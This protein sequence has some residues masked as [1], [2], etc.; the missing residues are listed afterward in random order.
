MLFDSKAD[1]CPEFCKNIRQY[2][3]AHAFTS[4]GAKIDVNILQ[5]H[6]SYSFGIHRE[7]RHLL[8][9]LLPNADQEATYAQLYIYDPDAHKILLQ[10]HEDGTDEDVAIYLHHKNMTDKHHYNLPMINK[11]MCDIII[12]LCKDLLER[13]HERHPA[14]LPLHYVLLF[15]H[16][17][18]GWHKGLCH[19]LTDT[20]EQQ[21]D[22][23]NK[24]SRL[25]QMNFYSFHI[26]PRK[27]EFST[28][29]QGEKL[30]HEFM[31]DT[32]A[33]TEQN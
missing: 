6:N 4:L 33:A 7:L 18:L 27:T 14:Y 12:Q 9:A 11:T 5:G 13:I 19:V 3:A 26:F 1:P 16:N 22:N 28:I 2:N 25:T 31:V 24:H 8:G 15:S 20:E 30:L 10:A 32:W 17:K 21:L 23:Q 29:L